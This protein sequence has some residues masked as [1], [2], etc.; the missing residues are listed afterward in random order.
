MTAEE[1]LHQAQAENAALLRR[2]EQ[3]S[4]AVAQ[5]ATE[6]AATETQEVARLWRIVAMTAGNGAAP[7]ARKG[8]AA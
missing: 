7:A 2:V 8:I 3:L 6:R 1:E 5:A 4:R